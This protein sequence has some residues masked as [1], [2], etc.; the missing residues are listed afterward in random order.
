M[1]KKQCSKCKE[2]KDLADFNKRSASKDGHTSRC[3][4]CIRTKNMQ[5]RA[6]R[7]EDTRGYNLKQRFDMSIDEYNHIFLKQKGRCAICKNAETQ[8]D[9]KGNVKWLSVDHNHATS[10]VRGLLCS[11][12]NTGIGKLGDSIE[13]L[14]SA[15]KYLNERGSYGK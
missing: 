1:S 10:E 4:D 5:T 6:K 7:P 11:G 9:Q 8:L 2:T 3:G 13:V 14:S 12:C 15:I